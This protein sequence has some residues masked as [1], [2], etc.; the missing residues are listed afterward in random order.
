MQTLQAR[1]FRLAALR[2]LVEA[3]LAAFL[4]GSFAS[5]LTPGIALRHRCRGRCCRGGRNWRSRGWTFAEANIRKGMIPI[6]IGAAPEQAS[7]HSDC[8]N[9]VEHQKTR[10]NCVR[11]LVQFSAKGKCHPRN[12]V[13][14]VTDISSQF[15]SIAAD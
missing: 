2:G 8:G 7:Q 12:K 9:A 1:G 5:G 14:N 3:L 15:V 13:R 10:Q 4:R 6:G 11:V